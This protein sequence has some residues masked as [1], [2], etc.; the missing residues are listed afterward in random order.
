M[1]YKVN[2]TCLKRKFCIDSYITNDLI[3]HCC[4]RVNVAK[5]EILNKENKL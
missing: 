5:F 4:F 2:R 3:L 1:K